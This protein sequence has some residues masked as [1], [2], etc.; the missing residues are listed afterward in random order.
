MK[1]SSNYELLAYFSCVSRNGLIS[2]VAI[3]DWTDLTNWTGHCNSL[4]ELFTKS[5]LLRS[6]PVKHPAT[7]S[8]FDAC[9]LQNLRTELSC[10]VVAD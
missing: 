10:P 2:K 6:K 7:A 3:V 5:S 9:R 1:K 4:L 8:R